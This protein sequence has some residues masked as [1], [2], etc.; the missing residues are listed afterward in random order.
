MS[1]P[2]ICPVD[3]IED[4][5]V[6][7]ER[8]KMLTL[9]IHDERE[10]WNSVLRE[11]VKYDFGHTYD[12]H[13]ISEHNGEGRPIL[14]CVRDN[15]NKPVICWPTLQRNIEGSEYSDLTSVYGYSGPLINDPSLAADAMPLIFRKMK[16]DGTVALFSRL[17]PLI[18]S[19]LL[20]EIYPIEH[21]GNVV[22]IDI[23][24]QNKTIESYRSNHRRDIRKS[25]QA[26]V[27]VVIEDTGNDIDEFIRIYYATMLDLR[28]RNYY[29][30]DRNYFERLMNAR[31][32]DAKLVFAKYH[33]I[34]VGAL[35]LL[36]TRNIMHYYLG[37]VDRNYMHLSPLKLMLE[38]GHRLAIDMGIGHFVLG[39]GPGGFDDSLFRFKRG[40]SDVVYPFSVFKRIID[41]VAY[42][43]ICVAKG[44]S[45]EGVDF[46]PAYRAPIL[47]RRETMRAYFDG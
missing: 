14:F 1:E 35:I 36:I 5:W 11:F 37:G 28:A 2:N 6:G 39:G 42:E 10:S 26:G 25:I 19:E 41:P 12:F 45:P 47:D 3:V 29:F 44:I 31:D 15:N 18:D 20:A 32:F 43:K 23:E 16:Q 8:I 38:R 4:G 40:F 46:F 13:S 34:N 33:G 24:R 30:F 17:H 9:E 22:S 27:S 7:G 21:I